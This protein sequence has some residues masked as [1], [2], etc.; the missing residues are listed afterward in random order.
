M[1]LH[2][3]RTPARAAADLP[4]PVRR[5][6]SATILRGDAGS[7]RTQLV[8]L[9][10]TLGNRIVAAMM[11]TYAGNRALAGSVVAHA[12]NGTGQSI[13]LHGQAVP[14]FDGGTTEVLDAK[15]TPKQGC[16]C[17]PKTPCMIG[18]GTL[19]VTYSV[20]VAITMPD[21]PSGLTPCQRRRVR[22]F[23]TDVLEPH[24]QEHAK[25]LRTY[26]GT[27][28][29]PF[30]VTACG[31][32]ALDSAVNKKLQKMHTDEAAARADAAEKLSKAIDPFNRD[33]DLN[34]KG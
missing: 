32:G 17:P 33:I 23:L 11:A 10:Q 22:D 34:C 19:Q 14:H 16:K 8:D 27:T 29:R 12:G 28:T 2:A 13:R 24:E 3:R 7:R 25:R 26:D 18:T 31:R 20:D 21:M 15:A 1:H 9:Q 30:S 5:L 6:P 4:A